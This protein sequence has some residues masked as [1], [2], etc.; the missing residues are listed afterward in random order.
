MIRTHSRWPMYAWWP[1]TVLLAAGLAH[2][3]PQ[4]PTASPAPALEQR[5][6]FNAYRAYQDQP[7][8]SWREA[9]DTVAR[10]GGWRT[11][12][13]EASQPQG[14]AASQPESGRDR[15]PEPPRSQPAGHSGHHGGQP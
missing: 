12:A 10:I 13:K 4:V 11:Y 8:S 9:N 14:A 5:S 15:A 2:A 1:A 7:V 3:Q 6:E